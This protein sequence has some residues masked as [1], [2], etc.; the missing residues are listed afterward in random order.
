MNMKS[1]YKILLSFPLIVA[2]SCSDFL[3]QDL[4][5]KYSNATFYK[6]EAHAFLAVVVPVAFLSLFLPV[7]LEGSLAG[8]LEPTLVTVDSLN[9]VVCRMRSS[10]KDVGF[11]GRDL[12]LG[13]QTIPRSW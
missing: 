10:R 1:I 11:G 6:T 12:G 2:S 3:E 7:C 4:T 5:G 13:L 9:H 8:H